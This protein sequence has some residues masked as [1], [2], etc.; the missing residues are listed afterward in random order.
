M[1]DTHAH[2]ERLCDINEGIDKI[3]LAASNVEDSKN[4]LLL[5]EK[6]TKKLLVAVGIHPAE[7]DDS[8]T[9]L[10]KLVEENYKKIVAIG[11]CGL[12]FMGDFDQEKQEKVFRAQIELAQ[13]YKKPLIIHA[14]KAVDETV[15]ILK[16]YKNLSGVFHC[17]A[18]GNK[19]IKKVLELGENWY[20]GIDGNLTYEE[21]LVDVVKNIPK[22]RLV[23]ETDSPYL[24][25][26][27]FRGQENN[28]NNVIYVY[29][30]VAEIWGLSF[31]ETEKIIDGNVEK[32]FKIV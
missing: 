19:R 6:Y 5:G 2:L 25:P 21:G 24:T 10:K 16:E 15:E 7:I 32:L 18:G 29:K 4:N 3:I 27:P 28:P 8:P 31:E 30:K 17:Y 23:L 1:I 12:E 26:E 9:E 11:E 22:D 14:R 20:F 13:K